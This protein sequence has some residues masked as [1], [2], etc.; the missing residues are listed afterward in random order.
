MS[1]ERG[2]GGNSRL[3]LRRQ[4]FHSD[5]SDPDAH[6]GAQLEDEGLGDSP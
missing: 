1:L 6:V 2:I 3:Q 4:A 5:Q